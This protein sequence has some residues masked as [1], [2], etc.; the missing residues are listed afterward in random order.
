M[1]KIVYFLVVVFLLS[2]TPAMAR[3]S[4]CA[5]GDKG[6][7]SIEEKVAKKMEKMTGTL[8]LTEEQAAQVEV[9]VTEKLTKKKA[10]W[11][12][13]MTEIK[14]AKEDYSTKIQAVLTDEQK[15]KYDAMKADYHK[16]SMKGSMKGSGHEHGGSDLKKKGSG[17]EHGGS[18]LE[19]KGSSHEHGGSDH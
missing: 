15:V 3:C 13:K 4:F 1:K 11:D 17:H 5:F 19:K 12:A 7:M 14:A 16:G 6:S 18:D 9:L 8:E 2:V 10:I